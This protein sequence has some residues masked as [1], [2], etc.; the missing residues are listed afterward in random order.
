MVKGKSRYSK[1]KK[2]ETKP[3]Q[4]QAKNL[5]LSQNSL[6]RGAFKF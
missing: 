1:T 6:L 3:S 5:E 4:P 2:V